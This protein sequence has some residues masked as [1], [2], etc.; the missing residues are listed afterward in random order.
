MGDC[1]DVE[2]EF[3]AVSRTMAED[4]ETYVW[5]PWNERGRE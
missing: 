4:V 5:W 3:P 2:G 1:G